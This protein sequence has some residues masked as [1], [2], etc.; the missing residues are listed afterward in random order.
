MGG[1]PDLEVTGGGGGAVRAAA[2]AAA[3]AAADVAAA[4]RG[5]SGVLPTAYVRSDI[6]PSGVGTGDG[7]AKGVGDGA[8]SVAVNGATSAATSVAAGGAR[9]AL[10]AAPEIATR[11]SR[12][13]AVWAKI[14]A[15]RRLDLADGLACLE[16]HDLLA[17]GR[18]ADAVN[19]ARN[20]DRVMFVVNRQL[21]P[22]NLC[23]LDCKFCDFAARKGDAHAYEMSM[24]EMLARITPD[25]RE[26]HIVGGLHP[27]WRFDDYLAIM[28]AIKAKSPAIQ[29]K[30]WTAVEVDWFARIARTS[31]ESV[32]ERL[33]EAGLDTL[34]GGGAEVFSDRVQEILFKPKI[35]ADRWLE[36]HQIAHRMGI[37]S[38]ATLL[39]G[40]VETYEE[41][42]VHMMRLR[43]LQDETGGFLAFIP[44]AFQPGNTGIVERQ[45]SSIEDLRTVATSRLVLDNFPHVK[46]YWVMLGEGTAQVALHFGASDLDGTIGEE[47]IAHYALAGSA[48]GHAKEEIVRM[49]REAGKVPVE[50]DARYNEVGVEIA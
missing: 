37:R 7:A 18:M 24:D 17:L 39:Y 25:L 2:A 5:A 15:G 35:G 44:L 21:N 45:A 40:H 1:V 27:T 33:V 43:D 34:P 12:L 23:I 11:D 14:R 46:S 16:S 8:A 26:V 9:V 3:G 30:A 10:D 31:I 50:R 41:R 6:T 19:R 36:V 29:I 32:L 38:N 13:A 20:G 42:V 48:L 4:V 47:R 28:N 22:T 49:I